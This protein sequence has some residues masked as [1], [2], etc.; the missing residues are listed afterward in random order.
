MCAFVCVCVGVH[1]LPVGVF[2]SD[3]CQ[4]SKH[5]RGDAVMRKQKEGEE[6]RS[7]EVKVERK[8]C[9]GREIPK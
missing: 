2:V 3:T 7:D 8:K 9:I 6:G 1:N 5:W 4:L